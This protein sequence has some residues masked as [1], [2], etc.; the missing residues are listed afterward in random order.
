VLDGLL[1]E[2]LSQTVEFTILDELIF[3]NS[4]L[5]SIMALKFEDI[6]GDG[7]YDPAVDEPLPDVEFTFHGVDGQGNE[8]ST[9]LTTD[10]NGEFGIEGL[11][12]G[13]YTFAEKQPDWFESS[14]PISFTSAISSR[15]GLVAFDGQAELDPDDPRLE[16][17]LGGELMFGNLV[18]GGLFGFKF[19]DIDL[20]GVYDP[21]ID[22][23]FGGVKFTLS[24]TDG[25]GRSISQT[26]STDPDGEFGFEDLWPGDY[27]LI[28]SIPDG[29][30]A[31]TPISFTAVISSRIT[32]SAFDGQAGL[33]DGMPHIEVVM[34]GSLMVGNTGQ[35]KFYLPMLC[36]DED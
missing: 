16:V 15:M 29:W 25:Q 11:L 1:G 28:E 6:N 9:T 20:N 8:I 23:P 14:T 34:G 22:T 18:P 33:V 31:T 36:I 13:V 3:G 5:G 4:V 2:V 19:I 35:W 21:D 26:V 27:T 7:L 12:A 32:L 24:G 17:L 30:G 10:A